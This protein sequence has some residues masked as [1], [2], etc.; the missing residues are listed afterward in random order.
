[1]VAGHPPPLGVLQSISYNNWPPVPPPSSSFSGT[2]WPKFEP[3]CDL[4]VFSHCHCRGT[5]KKNR[6]FKPYFVAVA[7]ITAIAL[8]GC[9]N[10]PQPPDADTVAVFEGGR[11][12]RQEVKKIVGELRRAFEEDIDATQQLSEIRTYRKIITGMVLDRVVNRRITSMKLDS[13]KNIKHVMKHVSEELNIS[14]LH[15]NTHKEKIKVSDEEVRERYERDRVA[16]D[17]TTLAEATDQIRKMLETEKEERYFQD[18]LQT[19]RKNAVITRYDELL[20]VPEPAEADVRMHYEQ[21]RNSYPGK[22]FE[23]AR[24]EVAKAVRAQ[25]TMRWFQERQNRT[26]MT[27]HGKPFTVGEFF[28]EYEELPLNERQRYGD[29]TSKIKLLDAMIDRLLLVEDSYDQMLN[30]ETKDEREHIREDILKQILHQEEVDDQIQITEEE[31]QAFFKKN[32]EFFLQPPQVKV[33]YIRIGAGKTDAEKNQAEKRV[34][35]AYKKLK[36]GLFGEAEPFGKIAQE[37]SEDPETAK[38]GGAL[39]GW[40][41]EKT[42]FIEE[43]ASHGFHE[44]VLDLR[45]EDVSLPFIFFNSYYIVQVRERQEPGQMTFEQVRETI[46]TELTARKHDDMASKMEKT[47]LDQANLIIFDKTIDSILNEDE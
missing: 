22:S 40:I 32:S 21:N 3:G 37:Y 30:T 10:S 41:S 12:T 9:S 47:L 8:T 25:N 1:M 29:Y 23:K 14:E 45:E 6:K 28:E 33:N 15:S 4:E 27:I 20:Q 7:V 39:E 42:E 2:G 26:L 16:F 11:I 43:I 31:M 19:L 24:D 5:M 34:K 13:R 44:N 46:Q 35:E 17:E 18:Y 36:P 38:N